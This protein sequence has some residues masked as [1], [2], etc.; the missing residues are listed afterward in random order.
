MW[1]WGSGRGG[2]GRGGKGTTRVKNLKRN[3]HFY[4]VKPWNEEG[5]RD[6]MIMQTSNER[7][8]CQ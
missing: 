2:R 4:L 1:G 6:P 5:R 7:K 3:S 8:S